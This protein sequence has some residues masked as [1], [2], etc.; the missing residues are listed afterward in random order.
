MLVSAAFVCRKHAR[1]SEIQIGDI[2]ALLV[3]QSVF[4]KLWH[5]RTKTIQELYLEPRGRQ[6]FLSLMRVLR[7]WHLPF[8]RGAVMLSTRTWL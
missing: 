5:M 6:P 8:S 7:W 2:S 3:R 1:A 4:N